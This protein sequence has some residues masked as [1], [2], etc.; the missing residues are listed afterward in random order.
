MSRVGAYHFNLRGFH[1]PTQ[2]S[3][4]SVSDRVDGRVQ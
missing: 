1:I 2:E 3:V 4:D